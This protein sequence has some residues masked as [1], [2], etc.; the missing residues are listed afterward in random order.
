M[1][2]CTFNNHEHVSGKMAKMRFPGEPVIDLHLSEVSRRS[3]S[4]WDDY[5]GSAELWGAP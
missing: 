4:G 2:A 1:E 5:P 3:D